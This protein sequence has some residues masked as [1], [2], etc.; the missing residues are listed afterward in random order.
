MRTRKV[1]AGLM[2]LSLFGVAGAL[3]P[4]NAGDAMEARQLVEQA[5]LTLES[6]AADPHIDAIRGLIGQ[7]KGIFI[8]PQMLKGAFVVGISGGSGVLMARGEK[9][10]SWNG[11]AFYTIGGASYGTAPRSEPKPQR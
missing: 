11:P 9:A 5:K 1:I 6:F 4:V 8:I 3:R 7:A 2:I 10:G